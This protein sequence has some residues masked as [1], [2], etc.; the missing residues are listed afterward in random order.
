MTIDNFWAGSTA[1]VTINAA[2][3]KG[4]E[5]QWNEN[6]GLKIRTNGAVTITNVFAND[7]G[8]DLLGVGYGVEYPE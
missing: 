5:F 8:G 3:G 4:N 7:N 6:A 2:S 1:G